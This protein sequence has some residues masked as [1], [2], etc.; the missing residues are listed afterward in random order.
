MES[1]WESGGFRSQLYYLSDQLCDPGKFPWFS[2]SQYNNTEFISLQVSEKLWKSVMQSQIH[3][4]P[5]VK[6]NY[7][8]VIAVMVEQNGY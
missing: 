4:G 5:S 7:V 6:G 3:N 2:D 8:S 1:F